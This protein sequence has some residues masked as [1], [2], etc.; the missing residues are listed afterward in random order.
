MKGST[1]PVLL[2][3]IGGVMI[4][5]GI[6]NESPITAIK[7]VLAGKVTKAPVKAG[8]VT[9]TTITTPS[10]AVVPP[11]STQHPDGT[12]TFPSGPTPNGAGTSGGGTF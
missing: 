10:G 6:R 7:S 12:Y 1:I 4:Y 9:T 11:G 5:A 2:I 3:I 8:T